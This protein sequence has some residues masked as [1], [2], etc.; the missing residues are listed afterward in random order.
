MS[1]LAIVSLDLRLAGR[2][3]AVAVDGRRTLAA[4]TVASGDG[5]SVTLAR[6]ALRELRVRPKQVLVLLGGE[7][8]QVAPLACTE[9]PAEGE[10]TA[11]LYAEGYERLSE[12]AVAAF[13]V[14]PGAWLVAG[15]EAAALEPLATGLL[16]ESGTEP[17]F[18][19]DQI[20]EAASSALPIAHGGEA[21]PADCELAGRLAL[22]PGV[23][24]LASA[25]SEKRRT[26]L[27][28]ARHAIRAAL[29]LAALGGLLL[30]AGLRMGWM[31][32]RAAS[33]QAAGDARL[34]AELQEIAALAGEVTTLREEIAGRR[35]PWPRLAE[36]VAALARQLPPEA[37]WERLQIKDGA[38]ELEA[39]ATGAA[40]PAR[41][42]IVRQTLQSAPGILNLSWAP[43]ANGTESPHL[44]QVFRATLRGTP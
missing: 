39:A 7:Q 35:A 14:S 30:A 3:A 15:C 17:V 40:S 42:E 19:V 37:G 18:V 27:V 31:R 33:S 6:R 43:P 36:P 9:R 41:L 16:E 10:I 38:L 32:H 20:L 12:P 13:A 24:A 5:D 34:A 21:L 26:S 8:T 23:P 28:W 29:V 1:R 4:W 22:H 44:R 2:V 11:T 25:R